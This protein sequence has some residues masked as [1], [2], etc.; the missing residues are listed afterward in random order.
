MSCGGFGRGFFHNSHHNR[1]YHE[2][3]EHHKERPINESRQP[4]LE[5]TYKGSSRALDILDEKFVNGE[6][7]EEEYL[8]KKKIL[9]NR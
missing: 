4:M 5:E 1:G 7:T 6:I 9:L 2:H 8:R 3:H